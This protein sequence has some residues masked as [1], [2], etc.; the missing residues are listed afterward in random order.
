MRLFLYLPPSLLPSLSDHP[1]KRSSVDTLEAAGVASRGG[2]ESRPDP[3]RLAVP[4]R[5]GSS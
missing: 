5:V 1:D 3:G 2:Q 4:L